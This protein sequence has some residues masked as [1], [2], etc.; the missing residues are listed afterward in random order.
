MASTRLAATN[1]DTGK[2]VVVRI[3]LDAL[4]IVQ[5]YRMGNPL[6][7]GKFMSVKA[8]ISKLVAQAGLLRQAHVALDTCY[9]GDYST[10]HVIYPSFDEALVDAAHA[11]IAKEL[12]L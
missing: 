12:A 8:A 10:G 4:E 5:A 3:S 1:H 6:S 7:D 2:C 9:R 11:A